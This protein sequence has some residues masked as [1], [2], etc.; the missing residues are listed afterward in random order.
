MGITRK[1]FISLSVTIS[2]ITLFFM[3]ILY[4]TLPIYYNQS[5]KEEL[6]QD[7][8]QVVH[9]LNRKSQTDIVNQLEILDQRHFRIFF[10]LSDAK[11]NLIYPGQEQLDNFNG[12]DPQTL[13]DAENDEVGFWTASL[14]SDEGKLLILSGE[15]SFPSLTTISQTLLTM[16]PFVILLFIIIVGIAVWIYSR[17]STKRIKDISL[18]TRQMQSLEKGLACQVS[19]Q[20]EIA[21]LAQDINSL[22]DHLLTSI[23]HLEQENQRTLLREKQKMDFLRMT[24]HELKTPITSMTGM[25]EGM[26]YNIGD[27]KNRDKYLELCH[28][29]LKDQA[30]IVQSI[31]EASK[32]DLILKPEQDT[33]SLE[34]LLT[35]ALPTYEGIAA[36]KQLQFDVHLEPLTISAHQ[37]Y[38]EKAIKNLLDNAFRYTRPGGRVKLSLTHGQLSIANQAEQLLEEDQIEQVFQPF[39]RPDFSRNRQDGGT[40]L[41]LYIVEQILSK[42]R[43]IYQFKRQDDY[44]VFTIDFANLL[45]HPNL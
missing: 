26:L 44:M 24:S 17:L 45:K 16:Y 22:Y 15:Y 27:F 5:K 1:S 10:S 43:L 9:Q 21:H 19:G 20:D 34:K 35:E 41:G 8:N 2:L 6:H 32:L 33:F 29:I 13:S 37:L 12:I 42:H 18:Q 38:L 25:I 23:E 36:V 30:Q 14:V 40:G 4:F 11:G 31:L 39:Y 7:F 28:Q 3:G